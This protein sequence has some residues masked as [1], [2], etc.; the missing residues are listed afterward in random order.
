VKTRGS[1]TKKGRTGRTRSVTPPAIPTVTSKNPVISICL[2]LGLVTLLAYFRT[3]GHGFVYYDDDRY[4]YD[5]TVVKTGLSLKNLAWAFTTFYFANWHPLTWISYMLDYQLFGLNA[6]AEHVVNVILHAASTVLLFLALLTMTLQPWRCALVAGIFALHPLHVE[7]VA[8]IAERKDVLS[9]FFQMLALLLYARYAVKPTARKYL[10]MAVAFALSLLAKPMAV[11]LPFVFLLLDVWPLRRIELG[12]WHLN[13]RRLLWEKTPLFAMSAVASVLTFLAQ[14]SG[15]AVVSLVR[16]P[17]ATRLGN[18]LVAYVSYIAK[19][20]W[21]VN[22]AVL[23]PI[24]QASPAA[25]LAATII[26]S[27]ITISAVLNFRQHPYFL[28]GWLWFL[29][30]LVPVIG[31]VQ[32][33]QQSMADRY[34]YMPLVGLSIAIVWA[35]NEAVPRLPS[36]QKTAVGL[37]LVILLVLSIGTYHQAGYWK[38]SETLFRH[39]LAVSDDNW[40]IEKNLGV[41]LHR[42]GRRDEAEALYRRALAIAPNDAG[43]RTNLGVVLAQE[44]KHEEAVGLYRQ[45]LA[46]DPNYP[47]AHAN[48]GHEFLMAGNLSEAL[49]QLSEALQLKE[50]LAEPQADMGVALADGGRFEEARQHLEDSLRLEPANAEV[51]SNLCFVLQRLG[52]SD[53]AITSCRAALTLKPDFP[54]AHFNLGN[55]LAA[56][57]QTGAAAAEFSRVLQTNPNHAA[58]RAA[59]E[60][61]RQEGA[62]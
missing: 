35:V 22:L 25:V 10:L 56:Q 12:S 57:G 55:A 15:G 43:V 38:D 3:F 23:Y 8:W 4:V 36:P 19:A 1:S 5:N 31:L 29:G 58:A 21:P 24:R 28:V 16:L 7:S 44:G 9:T 32:V 62:H 27:A 18:A 40:I 37:A 48:L 42:Q 39:A 26:L 41:V 2:V 53:Q 17:F 20:F 49:T 59:L 45:A 54:D 52:R 47:D 13:L 46:V 30:M 51:Q 50:D 61:L 60:Q 14:R 6:G 34:I 11:T 33:G